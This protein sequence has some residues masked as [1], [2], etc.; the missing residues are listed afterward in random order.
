MNA[1]ITLTDSAVKAI[2]E[3]MAQKDGAIGL[4]VRVKSTG[5]SGKS[6]VMEFVTAET[7]EVDDRIEQG[8]AVLFIPK[9]DSWMMFGMEIGYEESALHSG[10]T[11]SNP[12]ETGRCG[13][14]ES[15]SVDRAQ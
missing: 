6:Y 1:P 8:G 9:T 3:K 14:G 13:C 2:K 4:R 15:F 12:N 7:P 10:F 5:C 11:F